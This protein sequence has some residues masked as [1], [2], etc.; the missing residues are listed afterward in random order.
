MSELCHPAAAAYH[1]RLV[2]SV[3]KQTSKPLFH[4]TAL[5]ARLSDHLSLQASLLCIDTAQYKRAWSVACFG[6]FSFKSPLTKL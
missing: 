1:G 4:S 5:V 3:M 2:Y 6:Q